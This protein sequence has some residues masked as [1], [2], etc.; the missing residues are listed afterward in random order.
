MDVGIQRNLGFL[1][2]VPD[3]ID[4]GVRIA[5]REK[6]LLATN[7]GGLSPAIWGQSSDLIVLVS[8]L[9]ICYLN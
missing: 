7:A 3:R 1:H 8:S 2:L 5:T 4:L 6:N 9:E